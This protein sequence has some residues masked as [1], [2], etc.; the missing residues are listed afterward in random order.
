M[1]RRGVNVMFW[2]GGRH[3]VGTP[4]SALSRFVSGSLEGSGGRPD[5][6]G[7]PTYTT[8]VSKQFLLNWMHWL[9]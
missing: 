9:C 1:R 6:D 4:T 3:S 5:I 2:E 8:V 7:R